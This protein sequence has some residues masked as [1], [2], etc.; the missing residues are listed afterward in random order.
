MAHTLL[1]KEIEA[2]KV[3]QVRLERLFYSLL[4][5]KV[6]G[7]DEEIRPSYLRKIDRISR[8]MDRGRGVVTVRTKRELKKFLKGL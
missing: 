5:P 4:G 2:L 6:I 8:E 1:Q 7:E 3:R